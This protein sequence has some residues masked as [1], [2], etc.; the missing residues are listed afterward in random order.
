M[1][2]GMEKRARLT[3]QV[4][5]KDGE[6]TKYR[7]RTNPEGS[8][9]KFKDLVKVENRPQR[10]VTTEI[11]LWNHLRAPKSPSGKA[12][13]ASYGPLTGQACVQSPVPGEG[14]RPRW[15]G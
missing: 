12:H 4:P 11:R 2:E 9:H 8:S 6:G 14:L 13:V 3:E 5:P 15:G 7:R 1:D 10:F